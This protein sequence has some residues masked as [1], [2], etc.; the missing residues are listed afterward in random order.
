[1]ILLFWISVLFTSLFVLIKAADYFT[2]SAEK[3]GLALKISPFIIGVTIVSLGTSLPELATSLIAVFNG[4]TEFVAA[5]VIGSNIANILL[6]VGI[7]S[8][9]A[10]KRALKVERSLINLDL[11]LLAISTA[12]MAVIVWDGQITML[13]GLLLIGAF[14]VYIAYTIKSRDDEEDEFESINGKIKGGSKEIKKQIAEKRKKPVSKVKLGWKDFVIL[15][16]SIVF[17]YLGANYTIESLTKIAE[18]LNIAPA[19]IAITAVAIG[20]SLPELVVSVK[21][22]MKGKSEI[23][24]G[25]VIGSNIFNGLF[26][27]GVPSMFSKLDVD[28]STLALGLPVMAIATFLMIISGIS[29]KIHVWEGTMFLF[30][31]VFFIAKLFNIF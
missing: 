8:I 11:P 4:T 23:A 28:A 30:I 26:I 16:I 7:A 25:N 13:E 24:L 27:L 17:V 22:A 21:A 31:Y 18:I 5:N 2:V 9:F 3:I 19:I 20:T 15:A 10:M 1:M 29:K 12:L 6:I 14:T